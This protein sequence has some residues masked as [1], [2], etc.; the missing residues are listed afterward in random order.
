MAEGR[1][2]DTE[3]AKGGGISLAVAIPWLL[4]LLTAG[5]GIWQ[6]TAQQRQANRLPFLQKQLEL[7]FQATETAGRLAS[8]TDPV[9]WEKARV[10]FWR[11]YWGPLSI[12]ENRAVESAM[13]DL[14][15]LVPDRPDPSIKLPMTSLGPASYD[16]AHAARDLVLSSWQ[17]DL[18]DLQ[19]QR[20]K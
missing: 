6:F 11:L 3:A 5:V 16:L 4:A 2:P 8:E 9:E 19:G 1:L 10:A 12:V 18:P 15:R 20:T 17:V 14:G 13:V 7:C